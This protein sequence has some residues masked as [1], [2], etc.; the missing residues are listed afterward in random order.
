[1]A[2]ETQEQITASIVAQAAEATAKAVAQAA[3]A[4]ATVIAK[5]NS[6]ALTAIAILQTEMTMLKN[7]Q[8]SFETEMNRKMDNLSPK[9]DKIFG[10]LEEINEGR[11]TWA[12]A[13][14]IG[15]LFSLSVGLIVFTVTH[16]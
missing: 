16:I 7:Q 14:V 5:E 6:T 12:V 2:T 13:L 8:T 10:K 15:A 1:M 11:P 9:F 3:Q 4:A